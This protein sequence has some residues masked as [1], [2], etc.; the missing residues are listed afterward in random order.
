MKKK[1]PRKRSG[2]HQLVWSAKV[3]T[4]GR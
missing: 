4:T 3:V 2:K 1:K